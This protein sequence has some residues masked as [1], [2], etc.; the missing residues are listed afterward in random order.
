MDMLYYRR[1]K[2]GE[3]DRLTVMTVGFMILGSAPIFTGHQLPGPLEFILAVYC[4]VGLSSL[5]RV[6]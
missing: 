6:F 2:G 1:P 5:T 3:I 4:L